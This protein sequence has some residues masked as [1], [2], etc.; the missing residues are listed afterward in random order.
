MADA[1]AETTRGGNRRERRAAEAERAR[2]WRAYPEEFNDGARRAY[3]GDKRYPPGFLDWPLERRNAWY[4]GWNIG[5]CDRKAG[6]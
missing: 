4:A 2:L 5:Y 6:R 1:R 3:A